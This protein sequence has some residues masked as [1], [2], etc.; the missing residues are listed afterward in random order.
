MELD[1]D[2]QIVKK[3]KLT[4]YPKLVK[5]NTAV[6]T[7]MFNSDLE[8][9]KF[10]G[11]HLKTVS[12]LRGQVKKVIKRTIKG[13]EPGDFRAAFEDKILM[14]DII[15]LRTW[16]PIELD[17]FKFYNPVTNHLTK[18]WLGMRTVGQ[19]RKLHE[20]PIP[21]KKD[22]VYKPAAEIKR[23]TAGHAL[24][25]RPKPQLL[26]K[27]PFKHQEKKIVEVQGV[28]DDLTAYMDPDAPVL[29]SLTTAMLSD[30]EIKRINTLK[31]LQAIDAERRKKNLIRQNKVLLEQAK[32]KVADEAETKK[33]KRMVT[34]KRFIQDELKRVKKARF[35]SDA[36]DSSGGGA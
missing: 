1:H 32:Q 13:V 21:E 22:S 36:G 26:K 12:G 30:H 27:L 4:G 33:R 31:K 18:H 17:K 28:T 10:E 29:S 25:F 8:V 24:E 34:S 6:I 35:S 14:S 15:M 2:Y 11:A 20:L 23:S 3:L 19:L 16:Y 5:K 9:A 7:G